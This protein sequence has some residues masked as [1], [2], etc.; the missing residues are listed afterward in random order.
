MARQRWEPARPRPPHDLARRHAPRPALLPRCRG[1]AR[2]SSAPDRRC[3]P[4]RDRALTESQ[5]HTAE[6]LDTHGNAP[7][8]RAGRLCLCRSRLPDRA[9]Q[10]RRLAEINGAPADRHI[11]R[12][13]AEMVPDMWAQMEAGVPSCAGYRAKP[14][15][16]TSRSS[17]RTPALSQDFPTLACELLPSSDRWRCARTRRHRDRHNGAPRS[18]ALS[19]RRD[20][21]DGGGALRTR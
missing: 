19:R 20:G 11:G 14:V 21:H 3:R 1:R 6:S 18:G 5:R 7:V 8:G 13:V 10:R 2:G 17:V 4:G 16:R 15:D 9:H 12:T